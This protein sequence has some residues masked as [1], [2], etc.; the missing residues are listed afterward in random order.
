[1]PKWFF[2][3]FAVDFNNFRILMRFTDGHSHIFSVY[4]GFS[5]RTYF[6]VGR[7]GLS[8]TA[9]TSARASHDFDKV[10]MS[11]PVLDAL[12]HFFCIGKSVGNDTFQFNTFQETPFR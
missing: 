1:M 10:I 4:C 12:H 7:D 2:E 9:K 3:E 6:M 11:G 5:F 8:A